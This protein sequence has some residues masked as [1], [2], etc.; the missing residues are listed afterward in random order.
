MKEPVV[1]IDAI[2]E[3]LKQVIPL[4][5]IFGVI[6]WTDQQIAQTIL[7][8]GVIIT[9]IKTMITRQTVVPIAT[10][11]RQIAEGIN[12]PPNTTVDQVKER[13]EAKNA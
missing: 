7:V 8:L 3:V 12:S 5:I 6:H 1:I 4:L 11:N 13:V 10:A 9:A 2:A